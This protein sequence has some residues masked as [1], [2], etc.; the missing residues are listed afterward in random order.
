MERNRSSSSRIR[1]K[2]NRVEL[3]PS[4][5]TRAISPTVHLVADLL[6]ISYPGS[7]YFLRYFQRQDLYA[8]YPVTNYNV[9]TYIHCGK[10]ENP[11]RLIEPSRTIAGSKRVFEFL[12]HMP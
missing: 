2:V 1:G 10:I 6:F 11:T 12:V 5:G 9:D 7:S 8:S 4:R 3:L